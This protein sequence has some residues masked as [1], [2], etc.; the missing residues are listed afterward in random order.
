MKNF[1]RT[2]RIAWGYRGRLILSMACALCSATL[3]GLMFTCIDPVLYIL[4][5]GGKADNNLQTRQERKIADTEKV[6]DEL[7]PRIAAL[8][9]RDKKLAQ[10]PAGPWREKERRDL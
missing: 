7:E 2:L 8:N 9:E 5:N 3:W 1:S 6:V 10:A 4:K